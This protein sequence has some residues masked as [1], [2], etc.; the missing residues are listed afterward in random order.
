MSNDFLSRRCSG[1]LPDDKPCKSI[2]VGTD[3]CE[4]RDPRPIAQMINSQIL[5]D[6]DIMRGEL[7]DIATARGWAKLPSGWICSKCVKRE[8]EAIELA[9]DRDHEMHVRRN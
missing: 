1:K 8:V 6:S 9:C 7:D 5:L 3:S 2:I 4:W